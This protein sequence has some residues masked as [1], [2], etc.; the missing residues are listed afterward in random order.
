MSEERIHRRVE[1][2]TVPFLVSFF[3]IVLM[4]LCTLWVIYGLVP[5]LILA[6]ITDRIIVMSAARKRLR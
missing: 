2:Y 6:W 3:V 5:T 1:N 4:I